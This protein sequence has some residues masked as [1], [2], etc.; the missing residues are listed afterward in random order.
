MIPL[1]LVAAGGFLIGRSMATPKYGLGDIV[2]APKVGAGDEVVMKFN[3]DT[4]LEFFDENDDVVSEEMFPEG[5]LFEVVVNDMSDG[6][7]LVTFP[8]ETK[9][10]IRMKDV[11]VV[12]V[13]DEVYSFKKGGKLWIK[14]AI[15]KPG[16][17]R[18]EA[19]REGLIEG[20]EKLSKA[21]LKKLEKKGGKTAKRAYL[22][23]TLR[24]M[25]NGGEVSW[26]EW[27]KK[28]TK[29]KEA[30]IR[31]HGE[32]YV[33]GEYNLLIDGRLAVVGIDPND[34]SG[35]MWSGYLV[36]FADASYDDGEWVTS[37]S[38]FGPDK[39]SVIEDLK[40]QLERLIDNRP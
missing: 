22:A 25:E 26:K 18:A 7:Y 31:K 27:D 4:W 8:D 14:K 21:D 29:E 33:G 1:I 2:E 5:E 17:L 20:D 15:K 37:G 10:A 11:D 36:D 19:K 34:Y 38:S 9:A 6:H 30:Y 40:Q 39:E 3:D 35:E 13:N 16:A 12:A 23:E 24:K 32:V 28:S